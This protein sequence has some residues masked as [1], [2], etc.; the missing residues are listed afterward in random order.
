MA[1]SAKAVL[2]CLLL[3][4]LALLLRRS[5]RP[6]RPK[7]ER[8][9]RKPKGA[10]PGLKELWAILRPKRLFASGHDG[11]GSWE[12]VTMGLLCLIRVVLMQLSSEL[13]R[14]LDFNAMTR[15]QVQFWRLMRRHLLLSGVLVVHRQTYKY[16]EQRLGLVWRR[17]LTEALHKDYFAGMNYYALAQSALHEEC[18]DPDVRLTAD[19][20]EVTENSAHIFCDLLYT[21]TAG[22][23]FA[24]KL[25]SLYGM[26]WA[27]APYA[28]LWLCQALIQIVAPFNFR[29]I[30]GA[31]KDRWSKYVAMHDQ[32]HTHQEAIAALKGQDFEA[33][34]LTNQAA[35]VWKVQHSFN[36][37]I[38]W[39][40]ATEQFLYTHWMRTFL[41]CFVTA[42]HLFLQSQRLSLGTVE[43]IAQARGEL[44]MQ[45][46]LF[47][48]SM[49]AAG[50]SAKILMQVQRMSSAVSRVME[51]HHLLQQPMATASG[52]AF[53]EG[54]DLR[55]DGV[56][57]FTPTMHPL[58]HNLSFAV[59]PGGALLLTGHNGAGKSSIFRCLGGL[60]ATLG[61][62]I[63]K[64]GCADSGLH[65]D[66]FYIPQ[67][68][69]NV[70]GTLHDQLTYPMLSS[71]KGRLTVEQM[72]DILSRVDL[73]YLVDTYSEA[74]EVQWGNILSLGETQRLAIARLLYHRPRYAILDECTSAVS[75]AMERQLYEALR[76]GGITYITIS[77]RPVLKAYHDQLLTIGDPDPSNPTA[78]LLVRITRT[79]NATVHTNGGAAGPNSLASIVAEVL[80]IAPQEVA[81]F[82][83]HPDLVV[84]PVVPEG[85]ALEDAAAWVHDKLQQELGEPGS[86]L[87][88]ATGPHLLSVEVVSGYTLEQLAEVRTE[89]A[90]FSQ[91]KKAAPPTVRI[92]GT[93][94]S[95]S[96]TAAQ[97]SALRRLLLL[98]RLGLARSG[99]R[100]ILVLLLSI[101]AQGAMA[102]V[103][104]KQLSA[105]TSCAF[106]QNRRL[107]VHHVWQACALSALYTV[108]E[109]VMQYTQRE[110]NLELL[111]RL[112]T[113]LQ[114]QYLNNAHFYHLC[115]AGNFPD[116]QQRITEDLKAFSDTVADL[117]PSLLKP[118]VEL[119]FCLTNLT[120]L[121]GAPVVGGIG[122]YLG[123]AMAV[124]R[125]AMPSM[126]RMLAVESAKEGQFRAAHSRVRA[127]AESIAFFGGGDRELEVAAVRL[128]DLMRHTGRMLLAKWR[129]DLVHGAIIREAP[130]LVQWLVRN[131]FARQTFQ[132]D[133]S[134][135]A[136]QGVGL[137]AGQGYIFE[138]THRIFDCMGQALGIMERLSGLSGVTLRLVELHEALQSVEATRLAAL[139]GRE[140]GERSL[141]SFQKVNVLT[142][143]N[144]MLLEGLELS[145]TP[146]NP[147]MVTGPNGSGKTALFRVLAGLWPLGGGRLVCP[148]DAD[149]SPTTR[150]VFLVPQKVYMV[151]GTLVDQV[152]YPK[153]LPAPT[154]EQLE[155]L[156]QLFEHV[157]LGYLPQRETWHVTQRWADVLSLGE[158][159]RVALARLLYHRPRF[160]VL[161]ECTSAVSID[162][163][164]QL[165]EHLAQAGITFITLS[166]R[167]ALTQFHSQELQLCDGS[168]RGWRLCPI[169]ATPEKPRRTP[170]RRRAMS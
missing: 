67:K 156:Q 110:V 135:V 79:A 84:V 46:V 142:P 101:L 117:F 136:D 53:I 57:V 21:A 29:A 91:Q 63:T 19:V 30:Q 127:H 139:E 154:M 137:A 95:A 47:V 68:P 89:E 72:R 44:G 10:R 104:T 159:Q 25:W 51:L 103:Y 119:T 100:R 45:F 75:G 114:A 169:V 155:A 64:P 52:G 168:E 134:V 49:I 70:V 83:Q 115:Q 17:K 145:V 16:I 56:T 90:M 124:L 71:D 161:D 11:A 146:E 23:F 65:H 26:P 123:F 4:V 132:S 62:T 80:G 121:A 8:S 166:E 120:R 1:R 102:V 108:A 82:P 24:G 111:T 143:T 92:G 93:S 128:Q 138:I 7:P 152:T 118:L 112:T 20:K 133:Q 129:Y 116:P 131:E 164:L 77:H 43:E 38:L 59:Q 2:L 34:M 40:N 167:L 13:V 160:A 76:A 158:Q 122:M 9:V 22:T 88:Q 48:Q 5:R 151:V 73:E 105:I 85:D 60:W 98:L 113:S 153:R 18:P 33:E 162:V 55:F 107:F 61:G 27:V 6:H 170:V 126:G 54:P 50:G 32:L 130:F 140:Q 150:D 149:G 148:G 81:T 14:E 37:K 39:R 109:Q 147:L 87:A 106:N 78:R 74:P 69:Y 36:R 3:A 15:D 86:A 42:P 141:I 31:I 125:V 163:E 58:V 99:Y 165:Y 157:G 96:P 28:Y 41:S 35:E 94:S 97:T 12:M 66:V 144:R